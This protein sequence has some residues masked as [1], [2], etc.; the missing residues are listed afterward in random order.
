VVLTWRL[1]AWSV[2]GESG[3]CKAGSRLREV[4]VK[5]PCSPFER[6]ENK[7]AIDLLLEAKNTLLVANGFRKLK[8]RF[9]NGK[10][11]SDVTVDARKTDGP[12]TALFISGLGMEFSTVH[13][14]TGLLYSTSTERE[15]EHR[16]VIVTWSLKL[17]HRLCFK[18][19]MSLQFWVFIHFTRT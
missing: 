16:R 14:S 19:V 8:S 10:G 5:M 17:G 9:G 7:K 6:E 11:R 13:T 15:E 4:A 2:V 18:A 3:D 1:E 12:C